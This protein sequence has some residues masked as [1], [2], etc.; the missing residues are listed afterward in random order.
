[1]PSDKGLTI[2]KEQRYVSKDHPSLTDII[3]DF[4]G[5]SCPTGSP[6]L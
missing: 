5:A 3:H 6:P 4:S 2:V 1:M